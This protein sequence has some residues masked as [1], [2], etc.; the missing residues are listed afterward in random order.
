M[1]LRQTMYGGECPLDKF[2]VDIPAGGG[3]YTN[4]PL[5]CC[6]HCNFADLSGEGFDL[7]KICLCPADMTWDEYDLLRAAYSQIPGEK[8]KP[9]FRAYV[10]QN[11]IKK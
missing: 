8:S 9:G 5:E 3:C 2:K 6:L 7:E 4:D 10:E 1:V 11:R